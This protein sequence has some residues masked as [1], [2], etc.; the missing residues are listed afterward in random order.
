MNFDEWYNSE[1]TKVLF[2]SI[3]EDYIPKAD[4]DCGISRAEWHDKAWALYH[5]KTFD[6]TALAKVNVHTIRAV[7]NATYDALSKSGK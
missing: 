3:L 6:D 2:K 5:A 7:F 1:Y 4:I